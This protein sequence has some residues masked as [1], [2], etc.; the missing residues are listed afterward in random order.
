MTYIQL[1]Y[2]FLKINN[3]YYDF[4]YYLKDNHIMTSSRC[5]QNLDDAKYYMGNQNVKNYIVYAFIWG[6][7]KQ[8]H[9]FWEN[10]HNKWENIIEYDTSVKPY[11]IVNT[12][13][14]LSLKL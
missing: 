7:T 11:D 4:I 8:G 10:L 14:I 2:R 3:A 5:M 6:N 12:N 9:V 1:F 13:K